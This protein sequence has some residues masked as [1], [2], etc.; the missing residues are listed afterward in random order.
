MLQK[1]CKFVPS[2]HFLWYSNR[3]WNKRRQSGTRQAERKPRWQGPWG[4]SR[5]RWPLE[6]TNQESQKLSKHS[7][8]LM[9]VTIKL[10]YV[11]M[12]KKKWLRFT[13]EE[14]VY[15]FIRIITVVFITIWNIFGVTLREI[16]LIKNLTSVD[17]KKDFDSNWKH[18]SSSPKQPTLLPESP[19]FTTQQIDGSSLL[20]RF[21]NFRLFGPKDDN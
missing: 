7:P 10:Y 21:F 20:D 6:W 4:T 18:P 1:F 9:K 8:I 15:F 3:K 11:L 17:K 13:I 12:L 19:P 14:S 2:L 5:T 16:T